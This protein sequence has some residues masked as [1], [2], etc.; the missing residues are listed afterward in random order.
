MK[1]K[2]FIRCKTAYLR[3]VFEVNKF[4]VQLTFT[5]EGRVF[6]RANFGG[7]ELERTFDASQADELT[8]LDLLEG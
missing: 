6:A 1:K 8:P 2:C 5:G 3:G 7:L 4:G